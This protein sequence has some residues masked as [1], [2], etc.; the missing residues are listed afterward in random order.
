MAQ[1]SFPHRTIHLDF[2]TGPDI[3]N[4]ASDFNAK[5]FAK[6]FQDAHVD[7]VTVFATCHHGH[8]YYKTTHPCR[9]PGLPAG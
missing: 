6:P 5:K 1:F 2:H 9:H 7:R 3:P 8:A 4:V